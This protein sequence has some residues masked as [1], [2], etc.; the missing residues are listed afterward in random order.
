ML[1]SKIHI[2]NNK[3]YH[4]S[5]KNDYKKSY[6]HNLYNLIILKLKCDVFVIPYMFIEV[7]VSIN[8]YKH[9]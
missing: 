7:F 5:T 1:L 2:M 4:N 6:I 3:Q 8:Y 9:S